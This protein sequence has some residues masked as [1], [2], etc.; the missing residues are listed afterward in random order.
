MSFIGSVSHGSVSHKVLS[1]LATGGFLALLSG[2]SSNSKAAPSPP[3]QV[4]EVATVLQQDTP[5]Y[6]EWVAT[7][8]GFVNAQIQPHVSGYIIRQNYREGSVVAKGDVLFEIDPRLFKA[9][10]DQA[11]AQLAQAEAQLG[12][13][14]LDVERDTP[15]AQARAI[16]Q[17]QLDTEIQAKLG[18]QAQVQAAQANVEQAELNVEWTKVTSL[19]NG[20][21]GSAQ[22]QIGNLVSPT[23]ILTSVSQVEPIKAYFTVSEQEF[24]DFHRR[25]PTEATVEEQRRRIPLHLILSDGHEYEQT[26]RIYFADREINPATGAIRIAGLFANPNNLLRPG[27]YGRIRASVRSHDGALLVPQKAVIELQG[28]YQAAVVGDDNKVKIRPIKVGERVGGLWIV[29]EGLQAGERVVVEGL[30]KV[31]DG[32]PV[33]I[34]SAAAPKVGG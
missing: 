33:K 30:L 34:A 19:V 23:S 25:F 13:A 32:S 12:K 9:A 10:L 1:V 28:N 14:K 18:A 21:A 17:S 24:T 20:I 27:G 4:V 29:N 7:L 31:R 15:L 8:D 6:S 22:V 2:C 16:A 11:K 5:I 26:G 3:P